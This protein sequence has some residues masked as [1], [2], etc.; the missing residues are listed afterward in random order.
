MKKANQFLLLS[1]ITLFT[2]CASVKVGDVWKSDDFSTVINK[3]IIVVSK[4]QEGTISESYERE[5]ANHLRDKGINAVELYIKYPAIGDHKLKKREDIKAVENRFKADGISGIIVVALKD[6]KTKTKVITE[7]GYTPYTNESNKSFLSFR[8][9]NADFY[10]G[11]PTLGAL[12]TPE[13]TIVQR[14]KT[15]FLEAV[16]YDLSLAENKQL[17]GVIQ[18]DVTDPENVEEVLKGFSKIIAKQFKTK[19]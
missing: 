7:G 18:A 14:S 13:T 3:Q 1:I 9:Y 10:K 11:V 16:V 17:V 19:Q 8:A 12:E 15:Y 6:V 2:S 4:S 5:I